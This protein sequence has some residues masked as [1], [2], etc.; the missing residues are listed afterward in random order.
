MPRWRLL[1]TI[2]VFLDLD[3]LCCSCEL[4]SC[5]VAVEQC[6]SLFKSLVLRLNDVEEEENG[7]ERKPADVDDV[8]PPTNCIC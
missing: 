3:T 8:V 2:G 4:S 1:K 7:F 5:L 6:S